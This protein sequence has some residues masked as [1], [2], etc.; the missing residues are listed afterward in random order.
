MSLENVVAT[1]ESPASHQ[2]TDAAGGE[3]LGGALPERLA[4]KSAGMKQ[5]MTQNAAITQSMVWR[6]MASKG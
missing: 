3:K 6:C 1:M 2:G 4:K 5:M